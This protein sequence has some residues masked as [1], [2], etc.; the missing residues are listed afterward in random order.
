MAEVML[1]VG[2][3][4]YRLACRDGEEEALR[5]AGHH[6]DRYAGT[7]LEALGAVGESRL[8]LM[9]ALQV[10]GELLARPAAPPSGPADLSELVLLADRVEALASRL[11]TAAM[12]S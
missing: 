9:A 7:I 6:L 3:R 8:L 12:A 5:A 2:G 4:A 1:S 11:E 10:T